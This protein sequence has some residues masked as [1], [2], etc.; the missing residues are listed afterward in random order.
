MKDLKG[1]QASDTQAI[2]MVL[3]MHRRREK[4]RAFNERSLSME[5]DQ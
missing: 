5:D 3:R 1:V 4:S 2:L